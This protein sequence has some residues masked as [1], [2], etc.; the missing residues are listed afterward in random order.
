MESHAFTSLIHSCFSSNLS[1]VWSVYF[2][3]GAITV[4]TDHPT[5]FTDIPHHLPPSHSFRTGV[6]EEVESSTERGVGG[7][8]VVESIQLSVNLAQAHEPLT[9][10]PSCYQLT[11]T[12][13][14]SDAII[15]LQRLYW[16]R[17]FK[18]P[19]ACGPIP[20][21]FGANAPSSSTRGQDGCGPSSINKLLLGETRTE[22]RLGVLCLHSGHFCFRGDRVDGWVGCTEAWMGG[23]G[24]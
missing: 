9:P 5:S 1:S 10:Q 8:G 11:L 14:Q 17:G 18:D 12:P 22:I 3:K 13:T 15:L 24:M 7:G 19:C 21:I 6:K 20:F 2:E 4:N 16:H 23:W